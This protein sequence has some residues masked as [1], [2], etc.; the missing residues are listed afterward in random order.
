MLIKK[1]ILILLVI[2]FLIIIYL[3]SKK[4]ENFYVN[5]QNYICP[6]NF[7]KVLQIEKGSNKSD[8]EIKYFK[9]TNENVNYYDSCNLK[10]HNTAG[11][12]KNES[13][14]VSNAKIGKKYAKHI[15][16]RK[17]DI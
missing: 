4:I 11:C 12:I 13:F 17:N 9:E 14:N 16:A 8:N 3:S 2:T 15:T 7:N 6:Q 10:T 5:N 1:Y